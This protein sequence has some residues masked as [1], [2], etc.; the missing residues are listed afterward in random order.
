MAKREGKV[1]P[2][3][4]R[5]RAG[6]SG[7][8][9]DKAPRPP[10]EAEPIPPGLTHREQDLWIIDGEIAET[11]RALAVAR[12]KVA[13]GG[14]TH[15]LPALS[16]LLRDLL[17][18]REELRPPLEPTEDGDERRWRQDAD[19]VLQKIEAGVKRIE[20]ALASGAS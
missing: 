3:S 2:G 5:R 19:A 14:T 11:R 13:G 15:G 17:E 12:A 18:R 10:V 8:K 16:K 1:S 7:A 6:P 9:A 4:A 20:A